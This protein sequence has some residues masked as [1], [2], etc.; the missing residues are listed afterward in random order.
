MNANF[1]LDDDLHYRLKIQAA[2][3]RTTMSSVCVRAI[4][5][6]VERAER[7]KNDNDKEIQNQNRR[8]NE[9]SAN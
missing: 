5:E 1:I 7:E 8:E 9:D 3:K 6:F 2:K 4:R